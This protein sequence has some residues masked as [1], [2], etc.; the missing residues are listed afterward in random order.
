MFQRKGRRELPRIA[1][2]VII[3]GISI[4][5]AF[6]RYTEWICN[7]FFA[8]RF[9]NLFLNIDIFNKLQSSPLAL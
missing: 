8:Y 3:N 1:L 7:V 4:D 6:A 9:L 5:Q 2:Q